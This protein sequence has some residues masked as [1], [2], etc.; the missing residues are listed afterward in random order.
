A[1]KAA[2]AEKAT[3]RAAA[4]VASAAEEEKASGEAAGKTAQE[5]SASSEKKV[6]APVADSGT[7]PAVKNAVPAVKASA[8]AEKKAVKPAAKAEAPKAG[9]A[10]AEKKKATASDE[11]RKTPRKAESAKPSS[12][13][14]AVD[15]A[16]ADARSGRLAPVEDI[17]VEDDPAKEYDRVVTSAKFSMKGSLIK[18]TLRGNSPMIGHFYVLEDPDRVVLDLAGNWQIEVPKVPSNRLIGAVRVGQHEDKTR[19]VFDMKNPGKAALVPL[20]RNALEL[21]IQ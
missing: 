7:A 11:S 15:A 17:L 3:E 4:M 13:V 19:L 16:L 9:V 20:N 21:R 18:L 6:T 14:S 12:K 1:A 10:K 2:E 8:P 5:I